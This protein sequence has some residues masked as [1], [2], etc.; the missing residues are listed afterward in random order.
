VRRRVE[1]NAVLVIDDDPDYRELIR[2]L[3]EGAGFVLFEAA[4]C[5]EGLR[6]LERERAQIRLIL[7]D[8]FMPGMEPIPCASSLRARAG[9]DVA[10]VLVTA[11]ANAAQCA[12]ELGLGRW[13]SKPF[14]FNQLGRLVHA[15]MA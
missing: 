2:G 1:R 6:L 3:L 15:V 9:K 8:Y 4:D 11:A 14:D 5:V 13:L 10:I 12:R 7:L